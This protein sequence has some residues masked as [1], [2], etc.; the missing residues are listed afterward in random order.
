MKRI[1]KL[2]TRLYPTTWRRRYG[3]EYE[4]LLE[5]KTPRIRDMFDV[6]WAAMKMQM[7]SPA[8]VKIVLPCAMAG[9]VAAL[10]FSLTKPVRYSSHTVMTVTTYPSSSREVDFHRVFFDAISD[11][12]L[13]EIIQKWNLYPAERARMPLQDVIVKMR[14]GIEVRPFATPV[15][16]VRRFD[17]EFQ[18]ADPP[19]AQRVDSELVGAIVVYNLLNAEAHPGMRETFRVT[20]PPNLPQRPDGLS[21]IQFAALGLLVGLAGGLGAAAIVGRHCRSTAVG[22]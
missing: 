18:Y 11:Q 12:A 20:N 1:L 15:A 2:L 21:R 19:V 16:G 22:A 5:E 10:A 7:T 8:F 17:I 13:A 9:L 4:A 3:E 6:A 14:K